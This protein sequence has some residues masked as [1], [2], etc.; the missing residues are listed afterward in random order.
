M[1]EL[2]VDEDAGNFPSL[3]RSSDALP[4]LAL[5]RLPS[6]RSHAPHLAA[7]VDGSHNLCA[8]DQRSWPPTPRRSATGIALH[9]SEPRMFS[10]LIHFRWAVSIP[11]LKIDMCDALAHHFR[12][13]VDAG[14]ESRE[15]LLRA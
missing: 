12:P 6:F 14:S 1:R 8:V 15:Q 7:P 13:H 5:G 11:V 4:L 10:S 9:L 3:N 2:T